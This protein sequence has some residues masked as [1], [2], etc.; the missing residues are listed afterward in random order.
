MNN[1]NCQFCGQDLQKCICPSVAQFF[2][3][4]GHLMA[5]ESGVRREQEEKKKFFYVKGPNVLIN[6]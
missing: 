5:S 4:N 1:N 6:Q 3:D 2:S